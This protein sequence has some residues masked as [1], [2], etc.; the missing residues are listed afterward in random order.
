MV[1]LHSKELADALN[2]VKLQVGVKES[3]TDDMK[4]LCDAMDTKVPFLP[5]YGEKEYKLYLPAADY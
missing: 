3:Y 4:Y 2:E 5:V 1:A